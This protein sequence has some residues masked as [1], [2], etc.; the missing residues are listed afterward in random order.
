MSTLETIV[1]RAAADPDFRQRLARDPEG[2][3]RAEGAALSPEDLQSLRGALNSPNP[4]E[5][6]QARISHG[7]GIA[8]GGTSTG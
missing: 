7:R 4:V 5:A 1:E 3:A 6:L 8:G 2:T